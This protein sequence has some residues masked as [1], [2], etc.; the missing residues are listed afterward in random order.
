MV[1]RGSSGGGGD[2]PFTGRAAIGYDHGYDGEIFY[3][4][5]ALDP[6]YVEGWVEGCLE[7]IGE[8]DPDEEQLFRDLWEDETQ[9]EVV[10]ESLKAD[11]EVRTGRPAGLWGSLTEIRG[12]FSLP[13][14]C[15]RAR[16]GCVVLRPP[17]DSLPARSVG[18]PSPS[19]PRG[20]HSLSWALGMTP[21]SHHGR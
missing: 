5:L 18:L 7:R 15:V 8:D 3:L 10:K 19:T 9:R 6:H 20:G 16:G 2:E 12:I 14:Q 1:G 13:P 21:R 11:C 4:G 17:T